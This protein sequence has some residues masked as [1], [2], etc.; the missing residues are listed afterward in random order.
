[1]PNS[2]S[3][4]YSLDSA[5]L[6]RPSFGFDHA[7]ALLALFEYGPLPAAHELCTVLFE[8]LSVFPS[9]VVKRQEPVKTRDQGWCYPVPRSNL[10]PPQRSVHNNIPRHYTQFPR[11]RNYR[12][13]TLRNPATRA[14]SGISWNIYRRCWLYFFLP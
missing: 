13:L 9:E 6:S 10:L 2:H 7:E 11:R 5:F 12:R 1:M 14:P 3:F 8:R 4:L